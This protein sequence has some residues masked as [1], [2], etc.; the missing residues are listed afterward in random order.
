MSENSGRYD[1]RPVIKKAIELFEAGYIWSDA[2]KEAFET[3][4]RNKEKSMDNN[5][6]LEYLE[7]HR[8][9]FKIYFEQDKETANALDIAIDLLRSKKESV[10]VLLYIGSSSHYPD[11]DYYMCPNC[12]QIYNSFMLTDIARKGHKASFNCEGCG[13][14]LR[15]DIDD[16]HA[17]INYR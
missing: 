15:A 6:A 4:A 16:R 1:L 11:T 9:R 14:L 10:G 5:T 3:T 17:D 7:K 12:K 8:E 2:I 13:K